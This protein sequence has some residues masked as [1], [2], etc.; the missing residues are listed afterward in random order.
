M[1]IYIVNDVHIVKF[2]DIDTINKKSH[3]RHI[4]RLKA[5]FSFNSPDLANPRDAI[6]SYLRF[7]E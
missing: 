3:D 5:Q 7:G 4:W 2:V 6:K 1:A